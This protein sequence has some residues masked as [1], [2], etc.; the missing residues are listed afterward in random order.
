LIPLPASMNILL[1]S[2]ALI[3][4]LSTKG[5]FPGRDTVMGWSSLLNL[6]GCSDQCR[7]SVIA[8]GEVTARLTCQVILFSS[9]FALGTGCIIVVMCPLDGTY[10]SSSSCPWFGWSYPWGA[11]LFPCWFVGGLLL[12]SYPYHLDLICL[13]NAASCS[14]K[15]IVQSFIAC[16]DTRFPSTNA[17]C[18]WQGPFSMSSGDGLYSLDSLVGNFL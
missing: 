5:V 18:I 12:P 15:N 4:A 13:F 6:I 16:M 11:P 3:W 8:G 7:Y 2:Y 10:P 9:L 17:E 14:F 1:T